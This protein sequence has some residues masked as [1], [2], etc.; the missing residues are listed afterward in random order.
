MKWVPN[1][2]ATEA[3]GETDASLRASVLIDS[4][5]ESDA[6]L[7]GNELVKVCVWSNRVSVRAG[8]AGRLAAGCAQRHSAI[9]PPLTQPSWQHF[10]RNTCKP[11]STTKVTVMSSRHLLCSPFKRAPYPLNSAVRYA[12]QCFI[13]SRLLDTAMCPCQS[14]CLL[15]F[16]ISMA[17]G[18]IHAMR[19]SLS[20][21][22]AAQSAKHVRGG[23]PTPL[24][25]FKLKG[26]RVRWFGCGL[27]PIPG[28]MSCNVYSIVSLPGLCA[29]CHAWCCDGIVA[30]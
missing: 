10:P 27:A 13:L 6:A 7:A 26:T 3:K 15:R 23:Q 30:H 17:D 18:V 22:N 16:D 25:D 4:P 21:A 12:R 11:S 29:A 9:R 28:Y 20:P 14:A 2:S 1:R 5:I 19:S 24:A 8:G